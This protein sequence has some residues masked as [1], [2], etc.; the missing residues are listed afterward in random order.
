MQGSRYQNS[1][2]LAPDAANHDIICEYIK[3]INMLHNVYVSKS[4]KDWLDEIQARTNNG[5][6]GISMEEKGEEMAEKVR[7]KRRNTDRF[8][9]RYRWNLT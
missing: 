4:R 2:D 8:N 7:G 6:N 3:R 1:A 9:S 5:Q